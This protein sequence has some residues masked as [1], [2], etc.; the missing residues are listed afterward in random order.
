MRDHC[1]VAVYEI[2]LYGDCLYISDHCMVAV[3]DRSLYGGCI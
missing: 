1:V 3:Y 2:L